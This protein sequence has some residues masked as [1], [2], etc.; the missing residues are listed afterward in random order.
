MSNYPVPLTG[1]ANTH[2]AGRHRRPPSD[3]D[4]RLNARRPPNSAGVEQ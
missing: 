2:G 1:T 3:A 4:A